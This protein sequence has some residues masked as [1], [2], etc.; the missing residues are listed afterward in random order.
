MAKI[1]LIPGTRP[2][3]LKQNAEYWKHQR[4]RKQGM[5]EDFRRSRE[6]FFPHGRPMTEKD[7]KKMENKANRYYLEEHNKKLREYEEKGK[8]GTIKK[9]DFPKIEK[10]IKNPPGKIRIV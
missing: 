2:E 9:K 1:K 5:D 4:K 6:R 8:R 3:D 10:L 7:A